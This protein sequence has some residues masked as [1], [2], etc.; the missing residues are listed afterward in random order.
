M[1]PSTETP[2]NLPLADAS[3]DDEPVFTFGQRVRTLFTPPILVLFP[4]YGLGLI[5]FASLLAWLSTRLDQTLGIP[6]LGRYLPYDLRQAVFVGCLLLGGIIVGWSYTYLVLEGRGGPVPPFSANTCRLVTN[7]PYAYM[8]HPSIWGK[9]IGVV[10]LG[11]FFGSFTFILATIPLL[12]FWSLRFNMDKQDAD[13]RALFGAPY[14]E[15]AERTPRLIP[16]F[17]ARPRR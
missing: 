9:L 1:N 16:R 6:S 13:M 14:I 4:I 12:L 7:G 5:P 15:Y 17:S 11:V 2:P 10:G 3:S 8:R